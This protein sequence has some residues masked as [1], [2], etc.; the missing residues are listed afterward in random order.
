MYVMWR[1]CL[2]DGRHPATNAAYVL[3]VVPVQ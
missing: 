3:D 1:L 2:K